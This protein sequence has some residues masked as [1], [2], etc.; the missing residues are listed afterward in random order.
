[1][2]Q[3]PLPGTAAAAQKKQENAVKSAVMG[4]GRI[5]AKGP[6]QAKRKDPGPGTRKGPGPGTRKGPVPGSRKGPV[7]GSRKG[8]G[9]SK[10]KGSLRVLKWIVILFIPLNFLILVLSFAFPG[11]LGCI[12]AYQVAVQKLIVH[13]LD[14]VRPQKLL[15]QEHAD[16][17]T[18]GAIHY[19]ELIP[20]LD[21][22]TPGTLFFSEHGRR[23]SNIFIKTDWKHCGIFLGTLEHVEHHWGEA[24]ALVTFLRPFYNRKDEY[25]VF[26][27]SYDLGVAIHSI[28]EMA[29][30]NNITTLRKLLL[31]E[32]TGDTA[33]MNQ[34]LSDNLV[35][36]GKQYDYTFVPD[37]DEAFYCSEFLD[38][39][40]PLE[41]TFFSPSATIAG[42]PLLL[43]SDLVNAIL[44]K[45]IPSGMFIC[46]GCIS[47]NEGDNIIQHLHQDS[48]AF[49]QDDSHDSY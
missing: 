23:V 5:P 2:L 43:P 42:R 17:Y 33:A 4:P 32:F 48:P 6:E 10:S 16:A 49:Q 39:L 38:E 47:K 9:H 3:H 7:P 35:H 41:E 45:G 40:L 28:R 14:K 1:V 37:N 34:A 44:E 27:S 22:I 25:L 20:Y 21:S 24:H 11:K 19:R 15:Q 8:S 13:Q 26:D 12:D 31:F 36:L 46:K 18:A 30:L 29:G